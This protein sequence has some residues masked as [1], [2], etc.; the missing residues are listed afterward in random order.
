MVL[1]GDDE[2]NLQKLFKTQAE[3]D[4]RIV[5]E[6]GLEEQDLLDKKVLALQVELGELANEWRGFKF[7]SED[8]RPRVENWVECFAC[9][10]TGDLNH[11]V[12]QEDAEG[13]GGH[14]YI[15]CEECDSSGTS[16]MV[17]PL[18]EEYVDCLHFILSIGNAI[19]FGNYT[20]IGYAPAPR[21]I[22]FAF[23]ITFE[24][25]SNFFHAWHTGDETRVEIKYTTIFDCL[26][27]LGNMLG[28]TE[29]QI[30][31]AYYEKNETNHERQAN[32]Y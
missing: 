9:D 31:Q 20:M 2:L 21:K 15:D 28:F 22:E 6:K 17:N 7:W 8:Q 10:G 32:G 18:L 30:E 25:M 3:L 14:A 16:H 24:A 5:K 12:V 19:E 11:E 1:K 29:E 4:E 23:L 27:T 13:I 26:L